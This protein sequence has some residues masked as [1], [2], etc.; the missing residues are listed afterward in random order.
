MAPQLSLSPCLFSCIEEFCRV[1]NLRG[2][3]PR[4]EILSGSCKRTIEC[5]L[6]TNSTEF[7]KYMNQEIW[8]LT[9]YVQIPPII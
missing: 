1:S 8:K 7:I 5:I 4:F 9:R 6:M 3:N 2:A